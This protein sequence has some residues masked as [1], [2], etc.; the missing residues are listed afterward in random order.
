MILL[1]TYC[2]I[3]ITGNTV[4]DPSG[5][6]TIIVDNTGS[7]GPETHSGVFKL[8]GTLNGV[9]RPGDDEPDDDG[10]GDD[11]AEVGLFTNHTV[12]SSDSTLEASSGN[13]TS[14]GNL[15]INTRSEE[16]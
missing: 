6:D 13:S 1:G 11:P 2:N 5:K 10:S 8:D 16:H 9:Y 4:I 3:T 15:T 12:N 14:L 7:G